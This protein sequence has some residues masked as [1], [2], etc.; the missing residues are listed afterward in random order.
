VT[1]D[2]A[3]DG[4]PYEQGLIVDPEALVGI[5]TGD[6]DGDGRV[7]VI[8]VDTMHSTVVVLANRT[9]AAGAYAFEPIRFEGGHAPVDVAVADLDG[10]GRLD[11]VTASGTDGLVVLRNATPPGGALAFDAPLYLPAGNAVGVVATDLDGDGH[12]D[13][14]SIDTDGGRLDVRINASTPG[15]LGFGVRTSF[16]T[17]DGPTQLAAVDAD[18][19]GAMDLAILSVQPWSYSDD[20]YEG[21]FSLLVNATNV[22]DTVPAFQARVDRATGEKPTGMFVA[23]LDGDHRPEV[24]VLDDGLWVYANESAPGGPPSYQAARVLDVQ[25]VIAAPVD[26]DHQGGLDLVYASNA[27]GVVDPLG[28]MFN[29]T[30]AAAGF[31]FDVHPSEIGLLRHARFGNAVAT[32][33]RFAELDGVPPAEVVIATASGTLVTFGD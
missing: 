2:V 29:R 28:V 10:D 6:I 33:I 3:S 27:F 32:S 31:A 16:A 20:H 19:Q 5:A 8:G 18:G 9:V 7:D 23:D 14:A 11:I 13:L 15:A 4:I 24:G 17:P 26:L 21:T 22:G 25:G 30:T 12:P 1:V